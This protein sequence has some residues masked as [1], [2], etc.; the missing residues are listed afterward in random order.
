MDQAVAERN[1]MPSRRA[2]GARR[3]AAATLAAAA[4]VA[5]AGT[6]AEASTRWQTVPPVGNYDGGVTNMSLSLAGTARITDGGFG[7]R[8]EARIACPAGRAF[9]LTVHLDQL[10]S[11][12]V[13]PWVYGEDYGV[14]ANG[15][16]T[17]TCSRKAQTVT[18]KLTVAPTQDGEALG[19]PKLIPLVARAGYVAHVGA[20]SG[21]G[22]SGSWCRNPAC[23]GETPGLSAITLR[24]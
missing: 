1:R 10:T 11:P 7:A 13:P 18:V 8:W 21:T 16:A 9:T 4:L 3:L 19:V 14:P 24:R 2:R 12:L 22:F 20:V 5:A 15:T 23:A 17:G 6:G